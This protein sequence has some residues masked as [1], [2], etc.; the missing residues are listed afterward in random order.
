M[1]ARPS[2]GASLMPSPTKA[3]FA[4]FPFCSN[5][6]STWVTLS[7]GS[8]SLWTS[9][10]PRSEATFSATLFASPVSITVFSTPAFFNSAIAF[11]EF[12]FSISEIT[13]W[14]AYA[15]SIATWMIVPTEWQS[16]YGIFSLFINLG[17]PTATS[18][19]STFAINPCPL[20]SSISVTR[21]RLI[22]FP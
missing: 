4:F 14:P 20:I 21:L 5:N 12:G 9:S 3:S 18:M 11:L 10:M 1:S 2:T 13:I 17:L 22:S 7:L 8:N 19:P 15:P 16:T 6:R